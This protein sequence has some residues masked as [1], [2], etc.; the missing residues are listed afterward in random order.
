MLVIYDAGHL[1]FGPPF[2]F[3]EIDPEKVANAFHA[4]CVVFV[5]FVCGSE[6]TIR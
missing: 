6:Y 4:L 3:C 2:A 5:S 1:L